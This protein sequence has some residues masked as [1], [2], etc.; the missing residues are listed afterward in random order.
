MKRI[1][2][3]IVWFLVLGFGGLVL[4]G[5]VVGAMAGS[6]VNATNMSDGYTK[7]QQAGEVA[8]AEFGRKY[9]GVIL[10]GALVISVVG[11]ATGVLPGT[12]KKPKP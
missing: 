7:G 11:T 8:G 10:I 6:Q 1:F 12:K 5:A 4:G 3:G 9:A 2:F